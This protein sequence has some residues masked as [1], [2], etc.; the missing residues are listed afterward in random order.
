MHQFRLDIADTAQFYNIGDFGARSLLPFLNTDDF[1]RDLSKKSRSEIVTHTLERW[2]EVLSIMKRNLHDISSLSQPNN[3]RSMA[4]GM[5]GATLKE[6]ARN[7]S[8]AFDDMFERTNVSKI[9]HLDPYHS[10]EMILVSKILFAFVAEY[11]QLKFKD[12]LSQYWLH[13]WAY[14]LKKALDAIQEK[15][16]QV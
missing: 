1:N 11:Q 6:P 7:L 8:K 15:R 2:D 16:A 9:T 10:A 3:L 14:Q 4:L 5:Y 13:S 12:N